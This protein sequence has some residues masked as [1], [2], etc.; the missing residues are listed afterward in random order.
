MNKRKN[1]KAKKEGDKS[2]QEKNSGIKSANSELQNEENDN[3]FNFGG[4]PFRDLKRNL[5]CG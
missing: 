5:G 4:L 2:I 3:T 1:R